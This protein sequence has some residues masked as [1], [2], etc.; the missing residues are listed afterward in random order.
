VRVYVDSSALSKRALD[1]VESDALE[2]ALDHFAAEGVTLVTSALAWVEVSRNVRSRRDSEAPQTVVE[3]IGVAL[4][5][6]T[7]V[8]V[9]SQVIE[10]ARR[11][12]PSTLRSLDAIHL[13]TATLLEADLVCAYDAR[14]LMS[15]SELGF[16]TVSPH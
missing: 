1:E 8:P 14:L 6:I 11:L 12:G 2:A 15:A 16:A 7:A 13:A 4:S 3:L 9:S 10:I 5:G